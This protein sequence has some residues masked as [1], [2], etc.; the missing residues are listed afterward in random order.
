[1]FLPIRH[2]SRPPSA[3]LASSRTFAPESK[4]QAVWVPACSRSQASLA[5][6]AG[7]T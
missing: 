1:M 4:R 5:S 2:A 7:M 6:G 3:R